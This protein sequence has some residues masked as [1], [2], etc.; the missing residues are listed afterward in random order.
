VDWIATPVLI[1][2]SCAGQLVASHERVWLSG[3]RITD[4]AHRDTARPL[5]ADLAEQRD[6]LT[7]RSTRVH[8]DG[9][10]VAIRALPD[11]DALFGVDFDASPTAGRNTG[12]DSSSTTEGGIG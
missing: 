1:T 9:R 6:S 4:P 7:S 2:I 3:A 5:R 11:Y 8:L 12:G 10:V